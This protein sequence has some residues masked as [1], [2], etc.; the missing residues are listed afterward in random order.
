MRL[1][2]SVY[3]ITF[4]IGKSLKIK[5]YF[6]SQMSI[7]LWIKQKQGGLVS[8]CKTIKIIIIITN[9]QSK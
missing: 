9:L 4:Q 8:L 6:S 2:T 1:Q 5:M 7:Y 3:N